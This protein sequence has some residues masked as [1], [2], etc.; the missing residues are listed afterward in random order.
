MERLHILGTGNANATKC[1]NTCF[2]IEVPPKN[3]AGARSPEYFLVDAGGGNGILIQLEKAGIPLHKIHHIFLSHEHTD[4]LLGMVWMIRMIASCIRQGAYEGNLHLY[5]HS[6]LAEPFLTIV[7]LTVQGKFVK[8]IGDRI[9]L[10]PLEDG[11]EKDI[12]GYR[13]K[14]FD[15][16][17]VKAKQY[18]FTMKLRTGKTFTFAGDEPYREHER[19]YAF[20]ADWLLHEAFC[21]YREKDTFR[22]YEKCH[23]TVQDACQ[24]AEKLQVKNLLLYHTEDT[25]LAHRKELYQAEGLPW[26]SGNLYVPEDLE[27]FDL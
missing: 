1:Y 12:L 3:V 2:A 7:R 15:I 6:D 19:A 20:G 25:N 24:M 22:P 26:F 21:L 5:C 10:H 27:V 9:L 4:H 16:R 8:L 23:T 14:F 13:V 11:E 17:S 18:G